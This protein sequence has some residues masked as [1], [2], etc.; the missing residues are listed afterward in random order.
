KTDERFETVEHRLDDR[1]E[2]HER[3]TD[4]YLLQSR[5]D[6]VDR[7]DV[8]LQIFEQRL[9]EQRR[10]IRILREAL[11]KSRKAAAETNG[12]TDTTPE[13]P[14]DLK[15]LAEQP[16]AQQIHSF[17]KLA[18]SMGMPAKPKLQPADATLYQKILDWKKEAHEGLNDF[19]R[20]EQE[21]VDYILSFIKDADER[22]YTMQHM[23]RFIGTLQRIPPPQTSTDRLLELGS[24]LHI[25]PAIK[26]F[27]GYNEIAGADF[28]DSEKK[29]TVEKLMQHDNG[30]DFHTFELHNFNVEHDPFP[31][32]DEHFRVVLC[33]EL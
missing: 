32:P 1:M 4:K 7:T 21:M 15:T 16:P 27:C 9:D 14:V 18:E 12:Q 10:E 20:D 8:M 30:K 28:W 29:V 11:A 22:H 33:C 13:E 17:R 25:A 3:R 5:T 24:L 23:R 2:A 19:T 26:R 31:F 6:I